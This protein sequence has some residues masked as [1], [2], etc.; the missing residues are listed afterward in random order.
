MSILCRLFVCC[1]RLSLM[2]SLWSWQIVVS[3]IWYSFFLAFVCSVCM[4]VSGG[5]GV[6]FEC[7]RACVERSFSCHLSQ[8]AL[9]INLAVYFY[10]FCSFACPLTAGCF[11]F[12]LL[13]SFD[14]VKWSNTH[15]VTLMESHLGCWYAHTWR[16]RTANVEWDNERERKNKTRIWTNMRI[17]KWNDILYPYYVILSFLLLSCLRFFLFANFLFFCICIPA[18]CCASLFA[19]FLFAHSSAQSD[20]ACIVANFRIF[21]FGYFIV[22]VPFCSVHRRFFPSICSNFICLTTKCCFG[23]TDRSLPKLG[24]F[25]LVWK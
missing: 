13:F 3:R 25:S 16:P 15:T 8:Y 18:V 11:P 19:R 12:G 23:T 5:I 2:F 17:H 10:H 14:R 24:H 6:S 20:S 9:F 22:F 7:V 1:A 21:L 4:C